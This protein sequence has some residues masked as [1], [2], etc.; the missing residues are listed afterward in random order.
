MP[1]RSSEQHQLVGDKARLGSRGWCKWRFR[2]SW[3]TR[4]SD[5]P[6]AVQG[7][8]PSTG[9]LCAFLRLGGCNLTC[10]WCDTPYTWDW[11]GESDTGIAYRAADEL[12]A[13]SVD[14]VTERLLG[15]GVE[16]IVISGGEPLSQQDRVLPVVRALGRQ[17]VAV[18]F[19]TNGTVMPTDTLVETGVRF[20]V[21]PKLAHSGVAEDRRIVPE[22]LRRF[23]ELPTAAF[24]FVCADRSDLAEVDAL[25]G[26][27]N[28]KNVWIMPRGQSPEEIEH[29]MRTLA[30]DVIARK[31]NLSGRL[32][33][34][35]WGSKRGI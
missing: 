27:L 13:L 35:V 15:F 12:H 23:G 33:V 30:D 2:S 31:W 8:G 26:E 5:P 24:K 28:L 16:L 22:V 1:E 18:E 21:S 34:N 14:E 29:G 9:R 32:H 4:Y 6:S 3:S 7:E 11:K 10:R 17:G 19:E 20:N 25:V